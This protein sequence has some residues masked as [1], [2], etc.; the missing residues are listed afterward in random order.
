[1]QWK[2]RITEMLG[3]EYPILQA[4][5][6]GLGKWQF[7]AAV[8]NAGA[9]GCLTAHVSRTPERLR[10]DI[11]RCRDAT[12]KPFLVNFTVGVCSDAMLDVILDEGIDVVETAAYIGDQ[13][14]KRIKEAGRKWIHK[15]A[16]VKHALHAEHQGA[17][18][19]IIVGLEGIGVKNIDQLPTMITAVL[20]AR[21]IKV[22]FVI[23][24]GIGDGHGLLSA[25][26]AGADGIMMGTRFMATE[27]SPLGQRHKQ[28]MVELSADH[29]QLRHRVLGE[30]NPKEYEEIM[31]LRD[32]MPLDKWLSRYEKV[33]LKDS[34]SKE[35]HGMSEAPLE[36]WSTMVSMAVG[37]I[38]DIPTCKELVGRM[39]TQAEDIAG[40]WQS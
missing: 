23:A 25:M 39:V 32:K 38:D 30:P 7:A 11:R 21:E 14:G 9:H 16:T 24:G 4:A 22:P 2:S 8:C 18:A 35:A 1:M 34:D 20:A 37:V 31:K 13:Y 15:T 6:S 29:P 17:D 36:Y 10:E 40:R 12:D 28:N 5:L 33:M 26:G 19:V 3:C 27:E